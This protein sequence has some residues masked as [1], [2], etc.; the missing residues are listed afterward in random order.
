MV[1]DWEGKRD[2]LVSWDVVCNPK[3]KG[4]LGFGNISLR[5]LAL[6]GKWL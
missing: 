2:Y 5:N 6:L 1:K 3:V 4:G